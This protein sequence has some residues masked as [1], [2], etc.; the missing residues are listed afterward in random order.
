MKAL[1]KI[2]TLSV[3]LF[4]SALAGSCEDNLPEEITEVTVSRLF[5]PA[6][7]DVRV[8]HKVSVRLNWI[9]V[10]NADSYTIEFHENEQLDFSGTPVRILT[11]VTVEQLPIT[12]GGFG[13]DT[14]YSVRVK[15]LG[16][17]I[18]PSKWIT[19][20][21]RT[22]PEQIL[23]PMNPDEVTAFGTIIRWPAGE[24]A[25]SIVFN[26]GNIIRPVTVEEVLAGVAIVTG[27]QSETSYTATLMNGNKVR[28]S[29]TFTT[30]IDLAGATAVHPTDDLAAMVAA[31]P[32][33]SV[34]ALF[35]GEYTAFMGDIIIDKSITIRGLRPNDKPNIF[36]RFIIRTG[37]TDA[38]LAF[39][40]L[41]MVG[42]RFTPPG[43]ALPGQLEACFFDVGTHTVNNFILSGMIVR[44]YFRSLVASRANLGRITNLTIENSVVTDIF[45]SGGDFIDF[46]AGHVSNL[47]LRNS[48]FDKVATGLRAPQAH[49]APRA[50][51]R[52]DANTNWPGTST[53]V[54]IENN[55]F[56]NVSHNP[57]TPAVVG[58]RIIDIRFVPNEST[59]RNN[60]FVGASPDYTAHFS[61][62]VETSHPTFS[63]NNYF[64]A[65]RFLAG[66]PAPPP[67]V[68][69]YDTSSPTTLNPGFVNADAG[70]FRVTNDDLIFRR[71]GD[72]R[73]LP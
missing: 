4:I 63:N 58:S 9:P 59:I 66:V 18:D 8:V 70:N 26:P 21:F 16:V 64:N 69:K 34:L 46:R 51:I 1:S 13:G 67:A 42:N 48:T 53:R 43:A 32:P 15:A 50:F 65:S 68:P 44:N 45:C 55:T 24:I 17:G 36:N 30:L 62:R 19:A 41:E 47:T 20:T 38:N 5:S 39:I 28:G 3:I 73:W 71:V 49:S 12:V 27:L 61:E 35:P 37:A 6:G 33:G 72:P 7:L 31:A 2:L 14:G 23:F 10:R 25:T 22:D 29:V 40:D 54:L 60:L 57:E 52:L 11:G 56:Y